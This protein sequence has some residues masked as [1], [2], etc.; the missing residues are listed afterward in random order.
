MSLSTRLSRMAEIYGTTS[1]NEFHRLYCMRQIYGMGDKSTTARAALDYNYTRSVE[2][3]HARPIIDCSFQHPLN[4]SLLFD[5]QDC[6]RYGI[7]LV[8]GSRH[9][10]LLSCSACK[11]GRRANLAFSCSLRFSLRMCKHTGTPW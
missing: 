11:R 1:G 3:A 2:L 5:T 4:S 9:P 6:Q 8:N 10:H 7:Y